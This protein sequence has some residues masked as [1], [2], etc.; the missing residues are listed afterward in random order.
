MNET[1]TTKLLREGRINN[2]FDYTRALARISQLMDVGDEMKDYEEFELSRLV[3]I[4]VE[5][6]KRT[7]GDFLSL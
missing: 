3:D 2:D 5:F 1:I 6:E 7:Y 4:V